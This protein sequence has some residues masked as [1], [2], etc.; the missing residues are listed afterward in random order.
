MFLSHKSETPLTGF[1]IKQFLDAQ[2]MDVA[3]L[4]WLLVNTVS[5]RGKNRYLPIKSVPLTLLIRL[6]ISKPREFPLPELTSFLDVLN[7]IRQA[8]IFDE[9]RS[10]KYLKKLNE[11]EYDIVKQIG[12]IFG[13]SKTTGHSWIE[14]KMSHSAVSIRLFTTIVNTANKIGYKQA[15][16]AYMKVIK[17]EMKSR[18][19]IGTLE[20]NSIRQQENWMIISDA[21]IQTGQHLKNVKLQL[22]MTMADATFVFLNDQKY[23]GSSINNLLSPTYS[24]L[25]RVLNK[26][27]GSSPIPIMP[28]HEILGQVM[29]E[30]GLVTFKENETENQ[31]HERLMRYGSVLTGLSTMPYRDW[32]TGKLASNIHQRIFWVLEYYVDK[33]GLPK[34]AEILIE[35]ATA[36]CR[37]RGIPNLETLLSSGQSPWKS[38]RKKVS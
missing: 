24:L 20:D 34:T 33:F 10:V 25:V 22:N 21:G 37:S 9:V 16:N 12:F 1:S 31:D 29:N 38:S 14:K 26:F 18:G 15:A 6:L 35:C 23:A 30:T 3:T 7:V 27:P 32:L 8:D 36:E 13:R 28:N 17:E 5:L 2:N 19:L 11:C 4:E